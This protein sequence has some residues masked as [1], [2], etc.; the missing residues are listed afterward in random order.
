MSKEVRHTMKKDPTLRNRMLPQPLEKIIS[1]TIEF[2]KNAWTR[3]A[4][5]MGIQFY[6]DLED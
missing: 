6:G 4:A 1:T 5:H 3:K 2:L